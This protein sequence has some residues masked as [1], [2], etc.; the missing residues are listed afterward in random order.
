MTA[1]AL[2][3]GGVDRAWLAFLVVAGGLLSVFLAE[4]VFDA[5]VTLSGI[6]CVGLIAM[7]R[8]EGYLIGLYS[9]LSYSIIAYDNGLLRRCWP[10]PDPFG[11][12][13]GEAIRLVLPLRHGYSVCRYLGSKWGSKTEVISEPDYRRPGGAACAIFQDRRSA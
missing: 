11:A 2:P 3:K 5:T 1:E 9:S 10:H 13:R 7:G 6:L 8:R 12:G 4:N